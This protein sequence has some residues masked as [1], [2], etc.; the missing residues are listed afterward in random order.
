[1][2]WGVFMQRF[3]I[4]LKALPIDTPVDLFRTMIAFTQEP[5]LACDENPLSICQFSYCP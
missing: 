4:A 5:V 3:L 2:E 1:M